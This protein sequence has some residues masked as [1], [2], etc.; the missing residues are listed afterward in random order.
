LE[1]KPAEQQPCEYA[2]IMLPSIFILQQQQQHLGKIVEA[3]GF[4]GE[5]SSDDLWE[6]LN[7]TAEGFGQERWSNWMETWATI[8]DTYIEMAQGANKEW[9]LEG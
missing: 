9:A 5:Y 4:Q 1:R 6:W 2:D 8:C 3:V 7:E